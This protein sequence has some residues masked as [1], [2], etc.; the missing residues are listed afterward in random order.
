MLP[1]AEEPAEAA[2]D[3]VAVGD[4]IGVGVG[5]GV[6]LGETSFGAGPPRGTLMLLFGSGG[7]LSLIHI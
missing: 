6:A 7:G 3:A 4:G 1:I 5:I 2:G